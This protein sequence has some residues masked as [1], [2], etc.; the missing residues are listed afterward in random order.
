[1][2]AQGD[3]WGGMGW[4]L[5]TIRY[6]LLYRK[7]LNNKVLLSSI[8]NYIQYPVISHNGKEYEKEYTHMC[9]N[10]FAIE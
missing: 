10:H 2:V 4:E 6:K 9:N 5:G 3:G 8:V 7:W 1:M